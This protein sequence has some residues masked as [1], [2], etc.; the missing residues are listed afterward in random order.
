MSYALIRGGAVV[1]TA[2]ELPDGSLVGA[3]GGKAYWLPLVDV[4]PQYDA[5]VET[6]DGPAV[7]IGDASATRTWTARARTDAEWDALRAVAMTRINSEFERR[8]QLPIESAGQTWDAD[9]KAVDNIQG[10]L[11]V[12][13][14]LERMG[15]TPPASR[16]WTPLGALSGVTIT[17][18]QLAGLGIAIA[19]RKD[20]LFVAKK[21][22]QAAVAALV[23]VAAIIDYDATADWP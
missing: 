3:R 13:R 10:V 11:D 15:Q 2:T 16:S 7:S 4:L 22:K 21:T 14:E 8:W 18:D 19:A 5:D 6:L 23:S 20:V 12:Y 9:Q 17:R 1:D